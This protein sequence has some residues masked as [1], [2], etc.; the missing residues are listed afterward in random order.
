MFKKT[1]LSQFVS[2]VQELQHSRAPSQRVF[3]T[4]MNPSKK[5]MLLLCVIYLFFLFSYFFAETQAQSCTKL[6]F[7]FFSLRFSLRKKKK[8]KRVADKR[9]KRPSNSGSSFA[10][11]VALQQRKSAVGSEERYEKTL[12]ASEFFGI[13]R[14][15]HCISRLLKRRKTI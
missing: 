12:G 9:T 13:R 6:T 3:L 7:F 14:A 8:K 4:P 1:C 10:R 15:V 11:R 5:R 2:D